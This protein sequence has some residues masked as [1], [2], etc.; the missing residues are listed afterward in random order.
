MKTNTI[1][2]TLEHQRSVQNMQLKMQ[3]Q[4]KEDVNTVAKSQDTALSHHLFNQSKHL[5]EECAAIKVNVN[6]K[7]M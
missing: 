1:T 6:I 3:N 7:V 5:N 2:P 4:Q